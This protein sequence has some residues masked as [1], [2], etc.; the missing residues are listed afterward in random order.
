VQRVSPMPGGTFV[1]I[2]TNRQQI[3]V[4]R[5]RARALREHLFK[6]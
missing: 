3:A 5:L 4:S 1:A 6:L 2:L